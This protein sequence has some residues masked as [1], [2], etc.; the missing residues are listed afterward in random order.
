LA[1]KQIICTFGIYSKLTVVCT[2]TLPGTHTASY[3]MADFGL[4]FRF[5]TFNHNCCGQKDLSSKIATKV[6]A[7]RWEQLNENQ[8]E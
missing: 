1:F 8:I 6:Y 2:A 3:F 7:A 4:T 5:L